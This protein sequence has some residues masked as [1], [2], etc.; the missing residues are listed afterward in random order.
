MQRTATW[1][2]GILALALSSCLAVGVASGH[3]AG[4]TAHAAYAQQCADPYPAGRDPANPLMLSTA[5][6]RDP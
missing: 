5:P 3:P 2:A 4:A 6:G 1:I